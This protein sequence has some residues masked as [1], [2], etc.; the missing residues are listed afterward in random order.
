M[1]YIH[2]DYYLT[3]SMVHVVMWV[4]LEGRLGR[5][6]EGQ[7]VTVEG[8]RVSLGTEEKALNLMVMVAW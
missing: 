6:W 2:S 4:Q 3:I 1:W 5:R 8:Y 7:G